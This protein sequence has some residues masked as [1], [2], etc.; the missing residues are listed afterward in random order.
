MRGGV[1][2]VKVYL[3]RWQLVHWREAKPNQGTAEVAPFGK[4]STCGRGSRRAA[5]NCSHS[6]IVRVPLKPCSCRNS[7]SCCLISRRVTLRR[8]TLRRVT[9]RYSLSNAVDPLPT[10]ARVRVVGRLPIDEARSGKAV[11]PLSAPRPAQVLSRGGGLGAAEAAGFDGYWQEG[12]R[13]KSLAQL[14]MGSYLAG[15]LIVGCIAKQPPINA[16]PEAALRDSSPGTY[17][18]LYLLNRPRE[19]TRPLAALLNVNGT[20][21]GTDSLG[22]LK[23]KGVV[24]SITPTGTYKVLYHFRGGSDGSNP[25]SGLISV[26]GTL[27][28]TTYYG[29]GSSACPR[30]EERRVGKECR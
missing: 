25:Q 23:H 6:S 26:K 29:G 3:I 16:L 14:A 11:P 30:S 2:L 5:G 1:V 8:V 9:L 18:Q 22:G 17:E 20:L 10:R 4:K 28:G 24:Y 7:S 12:P 27:Y 19:G 21:Y 15:A 13:V